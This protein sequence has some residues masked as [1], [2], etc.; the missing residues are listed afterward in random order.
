VAGRREYLEPVKLQGEVQEDS[1]SVDLNESRVQIQCVVVLGPSLDL[2]NFSPTQL[3]MQA[4]FMDG[5]YAEWVAYERLAFPSLSMTV[6]DLRRMYH[7]PDGHRNRAPNNS[8]ALASFFN[9]S[10]SEED[11]K[12][13]HRSMGMRRQPAVTFQGQQGPP[14]VEGNIDLQWIQAMGN[15]VPVTY[16]ATAG[17]DPLS[18]HEP[19]LEWLCELANS[20]HPPLVHSLSY[21][22]NEEA[23]S[24]AYQRRG[25]LEL[26][27]LGLRGVTILAASG[28]TGI[29]GA[30]QQG[31]PPPRC[32]PFAA[33]WPASSPYVTSVGATM[34]SNH[35]SEVCNV[36][37]VYAMGS[38]SSM[39]FAC[40][41]TNV[42]EIVCSTQTGSM[43]TSG[44]GFSQRFARPQ[45]QAD[46][47]EEYLSQIFV[48][49]S[50]FNA[51]GRG[52][53]DIS[54]TGANV[55]IFFQGRLTMVGGTSAS[56]PIVAGLVALLNGERL[57]A[58]L[59]PLGFLNPLLY[60]SYNRWPDIVQDVRVGNISGTNLL[61]PAAQLKDCEAGFPALPGWDAA[62]GLGSPNFKQMLQ[63]LVPLS[64]EYSRAP[65]KRMWV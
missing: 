18:A 59:P 19:F 31:G 3:K 53:P 13:F 23:Y 21:G 60:T 6:S 8:Q 41:E 47:I 34:V 32:A 58:G 24:L 17:G 9:I 14:G 55:P 30:A 28:D 33:V 22:E 44:G 45:Y 50:L 29:Q 16:W 56:S 26:A 37:R 48:N 11:G 4:V 51:T 64:A 35:M 40:P 36:D 39:P 2:V 49:R 7:V 20:S 12:R 27:K 63:H 46:A 57:E 1:C 42:G 5:S 43:I 54:A 38:N 65:L 15:N 62:S 61:L 25:N 52:Y 10:A